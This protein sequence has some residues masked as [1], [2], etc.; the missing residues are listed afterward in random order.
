M[1]GLDQPGLGSARSMQKGKFGGTSHLGIFQASPRDCPE[2]VL[3][4]GRLLAEEFDGLIRQQRG[5]DGGGEVRRTEWHQLGEK[6]GGE[7]REVERP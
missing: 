3:L 7:R 4:R 1:P 2:L 6:R 5:D